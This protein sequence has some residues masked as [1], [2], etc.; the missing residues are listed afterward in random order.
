MFTR[1][2]YR[3]T[4]STNHWESCSR[5]AKTS[6][7][8]SRIGTPFMVLQLCA[9]PKHMLVTATQG[10]DAVT[11]FTGGTGP[12][13]GVPSRPV[14][15]LA[16]YMNGTETGGRLRPMPST[17]VENAFATRNPQ[18]HAIKSF[19][20]MVETSSESKAQRRELIPPPPPRQCAINGRLFT[21]PS[22]KGSK[23]RRSPRDEDVPTALQSGL[24]RAIVACAHI[25][26]FSPLQEYLAHC[27]YD[28]LPMH[29]A[30]H[31]VLRALGPAL[32]YI[33]GLVDT[34][35][36]RGSVVYE[37]WTAFHSV[38]SERIQIL[39]S[40]FHN[41]ARSFRAASQYNRKHYL[42]VARAAGGLIIVAEHAKLV[43]GVRVVIAMSV[44]CTA[45][46]FLDDPLWMDRVS[47][48]ASSGGRMRLDI[49]VFRADEVEALA[50]PLRRNT[51]RV[52]TT[53]QRLANELPNDRNT[54]DMEYVTEALAALALPEDLEV[55]TH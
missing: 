53:L 30:Y 7:I 50:L 54:W 20:T 32:E 31:D 2:D 33:A 29:L 40:A 55:E 9:P 6:S 28:F 19:S 36:F 44:D 25:P 17:M 49:F 52:D 43:T 12:V 5:A 14:M 3:T 37:H 11:V 10:M 26:G 41:Q 39:D 45:I 21:A 46:F 42:S 22:R 16:K 48:V 38:A 13:S 34:D 18:V 8:P 24:L 15:P 23:T 4:V 51:V 27:L 1:L 35:I 47:R